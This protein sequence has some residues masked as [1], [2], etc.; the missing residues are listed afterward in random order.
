MAGAIR[1]LLTQTAWS[2]V[3][4][5]DLEIAIPRPDRTPSATTRGE[6]EDK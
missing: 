1:Y 4:I 5:R 3:E 2:D 6:I